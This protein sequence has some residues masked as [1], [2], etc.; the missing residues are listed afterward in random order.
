VGKL[1]PVLALFGGTRKITN[2]RRNFRRRK[3]FWNVW[4]IVATGQKVKTSVRKINW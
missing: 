2:K 4:T 3:E 1:R